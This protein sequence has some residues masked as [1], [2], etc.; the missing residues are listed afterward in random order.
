MIRIAT[1]TIF[2]IGLVIFF[3]GSALSCS[4][5]LDGNSSGSTRWGSGLVDDNQSPPE[6][7]LELKRRRGASND[8]RSEDRPIEENRRPSHQNRGRDDRGILT[9]DDNDRDDARS[10]EHHR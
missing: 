10:R 7:S 1:S 2:S 4:A 5:I 6:S 3:A 9:R 8:D